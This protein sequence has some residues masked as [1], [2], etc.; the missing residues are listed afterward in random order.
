VVEGV[1]AIPACTG[2][3]PPMP[4]YAR[5][6]PP[7]YARVAASGRGSRVISGES[8]DNAAYPNERPSGPFGG[9]YAGWADG[10]TGMGGCAHTLSAR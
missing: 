10:R 1:G 8:S 4:A 3:C 5:L 6:C 9:T 2:L 7:R